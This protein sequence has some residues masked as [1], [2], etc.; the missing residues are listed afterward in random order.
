MVKQ[1]VVVVVPIHSASPSDYELISFKQ[2]FNVLRNHPIR[3][4]APLGLNINRYKDV[5]TNFEIIYINPVWQSSVLQYNKLKM[6][7][8]FYSLFE[9]FE[10]LLTYE[11]DAFV[12]KDELL[13]WCKKGYDY[14]GAPWFEGFDKPTGK[15]I[16]VGNSGFSLRDIQSIKDNIKRISY[17]DPTK[18]KAGMRRKF[19]A[20][21]ENIYYSIS[22]GIVMENS[23]L[24]NANHLF[25]DRVICEIIPLQDKRFKV[26]PVE[27]ALKFSFEVNPSVL[28]KLNGY[29]LPF[30]CH[31]WWRYDLDFWK[32]HI[33]KF[34][35][36]L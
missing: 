29:T 31:A 36:K 20:I 1:K 11:L 4:I 8:F 30:G 32:G 6:S 27:D 13:D 14:I 22:N 16:G 7:L 5:V 25:E 10:Y 28:Y 24:Q 15:I 17:R 35:F 23:A 2:C 34:G 18:Y 3:V 12:F 33:E 26:A 19:L 21:I 9:G